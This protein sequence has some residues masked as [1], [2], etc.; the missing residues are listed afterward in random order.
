MLSASLRHKRILL[1]QPTYTKG[2]YSDAEVLTWATVRQEFAAFRDLTVNETLTDGRRE[3]KVHR[4]WT[5]R[6]ANDVLPSWRI[7]D[8][9]STAIADVATTPTVVPT[10]VT[11]TSLAAGASA[12]YKAKFYLDFCGQRFFH[13]ALLSLTVLNDS[14]ASK[15]VRLTITAPPAGCSGLFIVRNTIPSGSIYSLDAR[16][17]GAYTDAIGTFSYN[18]NFS[19]TAQRTSGVTINPAQNY[20]ISGIKELPNRTGWEIDTEAIIELTPPIAPV[21]VVP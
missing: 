16:A 6:R 17:A 13:S 21:E 1:Q 5:L 14:A 19:I 9:H 18:P 15:D 10:L 20:G 11:G 7:R 12:T 2:T 3:S 8:D 4:L